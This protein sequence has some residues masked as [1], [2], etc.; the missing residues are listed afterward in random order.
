MSIGRLL[1]RSAASSANVLHCISFIKLP[2]FCFLK[3]ITF[4]LSGLF[5][6]YEINSSSDIC[7]KEGWSE[8]EQEDRASMVDITKS[9]L[10]GVMTLTKITYLLK[11]PKNFVVNDDRVLRLIANVS[12]VH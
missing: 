1:L 11:N 6:L 2:V 9:G 8:V 10:L 12:V 4:S 7:R 5:A 3:Q